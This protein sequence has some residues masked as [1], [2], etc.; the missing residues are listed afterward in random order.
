MRSERSG[1]SKLLSCI[2]ASACTLIIS[3]CAAYHPL[4]LSKRATLADYVTDLRHVLPRYAPS[5]DSKT[6]DVDKPLS[7]DQIGLLAI[8]NDPE[9]LSE[10]GEY[11]LAQANLVQSAL[12][13]NPS[14][15]LGYA[16]LLGGP[17]T[18]AAYTA[19]LAQD[20]ASLVTYRGRVAAAR[21]GVAKV[22]AD[23]LW[24]EWQVAQK[25]RLLSVDIYWGDRVIASTE[26]EL[27]SIAQTVAKVRDAVDSG[28]M[29]LTAL[30]PLLASESS[31]EQSLASLRLTQLKN[32]AN[33]NGLLGLKPGVRF[34][35]TKP[36]LPAP[37]EHL[38]VLIAGMPTRRPDLIAL[39]L[40]YRSADENVRT[41]ILGQ[42]PAFILGGTWGS[43]TSRVRTAGP[44]VTFD[45][46]IFNR[47]Q[48]NITTAQATRLL[49]H[50]QYQSRLD[51][52]VSN[53]LALQAQ[54]RHT[55]A[56][57]ARTRPEA[58]AAKQRAQ[59]ARQA[60]RQNNLDER[61][62]MDYETTALQKQIQVFDLERGLDESRITLGLELGQGLPQTRIAPLDSA[63]QQ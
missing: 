3:G 21:T 23:L 7:P 50:E 62:L 24:K 26:T 6:I 11:G 15:S 45:L 36:R 1:L 32:W 37:P 5:T 38:D 27:A 16:A 17:G 10:R 25:A 12:I 57:L 59:T 19:S 52:A 46:P 28:V 49:L 41:A 18:A 34:V 53:I 14:I 29:S 47:N 13:P 39:Q 30:T 4:P 54:S 42:F 44:T 61:A 58:A 22:N 55:E 51:S 31:T 33:L 2:A 60:Y 9:L 63:R 35:I 56:L 8:L 20:I 40:G 43:D 48:G